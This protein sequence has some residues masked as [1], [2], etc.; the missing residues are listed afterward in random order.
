M[1]TLSTGK[2]GF[3]ATDG[4]LGWGIGRPDSNLGGIG[5]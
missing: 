1:S 5:R 3:T 2:R 4:K